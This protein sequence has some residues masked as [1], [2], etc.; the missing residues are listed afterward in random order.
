MPWNRLKLVL[1]PRGF[2][3][4]PV[5][6]INRRENDRLLFSLFFFLPDKRSD[7]LHRKAYLY[8]VL[9]REITGLSLLNYFALIAGETSVAI[10]RENLSASGV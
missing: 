6:T 9:K 1:D 8:I 3:A 4:A 10:H 2:F 7:S 5:N